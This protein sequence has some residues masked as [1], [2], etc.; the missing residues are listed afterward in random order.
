MCHDYCAFQKYV[1]ADMTVREDTTV[2]RVPEAQEP[3]SFKAL[4]PTWDDN[5]FQVRVTQCT[6]QS[7][8]CNLI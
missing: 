7:V 5:L 1:Q 2:I 4:F 3:P 6:Q 8:F